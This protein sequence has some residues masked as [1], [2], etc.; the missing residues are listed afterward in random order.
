MND[1]LSY[2]RNLGYTDAQ[3]EE[4]KRLIGNVSYTANRVVNALIDV[5]DR[6]CSSDASRNSTQIHS[7][8]LL[9]S[10]SKND[11]NRSLA[12]SS[13]CYS[14]MNSVPSPPETLKKIFIDGPNVARSH[15]RD[16]AFSWLGI[17]I[18]VDW[19][20]SREHKVRVF[21]PSD[22]CNSAEPSIIDYL[23]EHDALI[24]TPT[25]CNDD[26]FVIEAARLS[27]AII[28][29][30]DLFRDES[31][32]NV[33]VESFIY[34]HRL[35]YIFVDDL[36]IPAK[37]PLGKAGPDLSDFLKIDSKLTRNGPLIR[38]HRKLQASRSVPI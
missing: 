23:N 36:F 5:Q 7:G 6:Q 3:Y 20:L 34:S 31:R 17:K 11:D 2:A 10:I 12:S 19:F 29:S 15:G 13:S 35:P 8:D 4:A 38:Q 21:V 30:N 9:P 32:F 24:K 37:D 27:N 1:W 33:E 16:A 26:L 14:S 28:V 25:G 22:R 18:C